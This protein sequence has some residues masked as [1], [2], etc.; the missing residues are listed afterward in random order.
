MLNRVGKQTEQALKKLGLETVEDLL[1]YFPFRYDDFSQVKAIEQVKN[2][3]NVSISGTVEMIQNKRSLKQKRR[4]TEALVSDQSGLI[5]V[6]WFNQP[7][8]IKNLKPGDQVSLA[9]KAIENYGQL[10]LMS[11]QYEKIGS[12][13][14]IHTQGLVPVYHLNSGLTQKQLR[15]LIKQSLPAVF[16][17]SEWLPKEISQSLNLINLSEAVKQMHFPDN[18]DTV[19]AARLRLGF[20]E[21]FIRQLRSQS[22]K[23]QLKNKQAPVIPFQEVLTKSFVKSLPFQLTNDQKKTAWEILQDLSKKQ[24][25]SRLLEGDVGSGKTM[26][27]AISLLNTAAN[28][29]QGALMAPTEILAYQHYQN[30]NR[31]LTDFNV[32]IALLT[33]SFQLANF[34]LPKKK[35]D[36][37]IKIIQTAEI[38]IGTQALIQNY[39][40]DDLAL[41]IVDEQHRFGVRQRQKLQQSGGKLTPHFLS[42]TAT[43]IPRSLALSIYGDLDLSLIKELPKNRQK[44]ITK[45][46]PEEQRE[47]AYNFIKQEIS[48]GRQAFV[49]CPLIDESDKLGVRSATAEFRKLKN[50]IFPNLNIGLIHGRL[51]SQEKEKV[52][53][54]FAQAKIDIL[55]AT[56]VVEVGVDVPNASIMLI[57][58][59]ERFGLSQLHQFRGRIGRG[60]HQSYCLLLTSKDEQSPQVAQRLKALSQYSDGLSIAKIDLELRGAGDLYGVSQ[61][62]FPELKIASLFDYELIKQAKDEAE[63]IIKISPNL[64]K[65]PL[66]KEKLEAYTQTEA[67]LE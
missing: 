29:K 4:L 19:K 40:I 12:G 52:M 21:L 38:I 47:K 63:K 25:M 1:F 48:K 49:I 57:E 44:I 58:G 18:L 62:G 3:D 28:R 51:K 39:Q 32:K 43:P 60:E 14:K 11:P 45:I 33:G 10:S 56:A 64:D 5:K 13:D 53:T 7:F 31:L 55:I 54:D 61:S 24:P 2:G 20:S 6:V 67:H 27:A 46:I 36:A 8:I 59:S 34:D 41:V 15:F 35:A 50:E 42:M 22:L 30:L 17:L 16:K 37:R 65:Y 23:C 9:G 26:V 66:L